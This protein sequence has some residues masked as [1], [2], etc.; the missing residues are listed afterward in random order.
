MRRIRDAI[1]DE[2]IDAS[3]PGHA[4]SAEVT[5]ANGPYSVFRIVTLAALGDIIFQLP[6]TNEHPRIADGYPAWLAYLKVHPEDRPR[7]ENQV[8]VVT[9]GA[10]FEKRPILL[11][12]KRIHD[13][14]HR[15]LAAYGHAL[16]HGL[17]NNLEVFWRG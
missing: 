3:P 17:P 5:L 7:Y 15:L 2:A 10:S 8:A 13:G 14:K 4:P 6:G 12:N 16:Q 1:M 9:R 11:P